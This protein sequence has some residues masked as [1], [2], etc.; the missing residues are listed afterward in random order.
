MTTTEE[1]QKIKTRT[2]VISGDE[3]KDNGEPAELQQLLRKSQLKIVK[4]DHNNT[5]KNEAFATA[6]LEFLP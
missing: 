4:G 1:L 6:V 5:Y 3:D 2:L